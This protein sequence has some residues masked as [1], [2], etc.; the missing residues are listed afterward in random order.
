MNTLVPMRFADLRPQSLRPAPGYG[1]RQSDSLFRPPS[2]A[3]PHGKDGMD[4]N[5]QLLWSASFCI[6][7]GRWIS[8]AGSAKTGRAAKKWQAPHWFCGYWFRLFSK[9]S[10]WYTFRS[11]L[12]AGIRKST[13]ARFTN[14]LSI[15]VWWWSQTAL[16]LLLPRT[17]H[18]GN[19]QE[20]RRNKNGDL[21]TVTEN[22]WPPAESHCKMRLRKFL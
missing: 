4:E 20:V 8:G 18:G 7:R 21:K 10:W 19:R 16:P 9:S 14:R 22:S 3:F 15:L 6:R 5:N 13:V 2:V 17:F 11:D 12:W 1:R